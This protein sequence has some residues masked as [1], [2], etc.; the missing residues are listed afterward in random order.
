[1]FTLS[2]VEITVKL[3]THEAY[4]LRPLTANDPTFLESVIQY[5]QDVS[6]AAE[7]VRCTPRPLAR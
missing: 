1:M 3:H 2:T 7:V 4:L 6:M 5:P